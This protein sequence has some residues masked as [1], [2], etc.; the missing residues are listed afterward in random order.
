MPPSRLR[1][2]L[3]VALAPLL[4]FAKCYQNPE[5]RGI[6]KFSLAGVDTSGV[7]AEM[8]ISI[9]N[10]NRQRINVREMDAEV[11]IFGRYLG[12]CALQS[13]VL[14]PG[15]ETARPTI[16]VHAH[17]DSLFALLPQLLEA[18][19]AEL[20][21]DGTIKVKQGITVKLR[22]RCT[23]MIDIRGGTENLLKSALPKDLFRVLSITPAGFTLWET[24]LNMRVGLKNPLELP[25]AVDSLQFDLFAAQ[26]N[27]PFG[28]WKMSEGLVMQPR[29]EN[30]L[31]ASVTISNSRALWDLMTG[32]FQ[33]KKIRAKGYAILRF[34]EKPYKFPLEQQI[35]LGDLRN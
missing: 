10:P 16:L 26:Q 15:R 19:S 3:L 31:D 8:Q 6:E 24:K 32:I 4:I 17:A 27:R 14:L 35:R 30:T 22:R 28:L 21:L 11:R 23:S 12:R 1:P 25:F 29:T 5:F 34:A 33:E 13:P 9:Y 20:T 18:D 2:W 7:R